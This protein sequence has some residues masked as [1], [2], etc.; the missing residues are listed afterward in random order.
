MTKLELCSIVI[1]GRL[2]FLPSG[3]R[4]I[5]VSGTS[6]RKQLKQ[7]K[8]KTA[9]IYLS[10]R[11]H[12]PNPKPKP[13]QASNLKHIAPAKPSLCLQR[14]GEAGAEKSDHQSEDQRDQ[15]LKNKKERAKNTNTKGEGKQRAKAKH[16]AKAKTKGKGQRAKG[17]G[18]G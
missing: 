5:F 11:K 3:R 17:E 4:E 16:K 7:A 6:P 14:D 2:V 15:K 13:K 9:S 10:A 12:S 1:S 18:K 8:V